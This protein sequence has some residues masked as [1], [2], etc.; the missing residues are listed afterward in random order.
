MEWNLTLTRDAQLVAGDP[1]WESS[2]LGTSLLG[3][4]FT[5]VEAS[6]ALSRDV[7]IVKSHIAI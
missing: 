1:H 3:L 2:L 6:G 7:D 4:S 5:G